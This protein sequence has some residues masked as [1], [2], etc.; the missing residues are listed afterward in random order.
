MAQGDIA[1]DPWGAQMVKVGATSSRSGKASMRKLAEMSGVTP[2][3]INRI[4]YGQAGRRGFEPATIRKL[5]E[6]LNKSPAT[7]ARWAGQAW[8]EGTPWTAPEEVNLLSKRQLKALDEIIRSMAE[9]RKQ[10]SLEIDR[11][12]KEELAA[13]AS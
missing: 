4:I 1:P 10:V 12:V 6:A 5:A 3:T 13:L 2:T 9:D 7:I 11:R 8:A